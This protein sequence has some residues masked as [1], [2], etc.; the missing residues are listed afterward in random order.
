MEFLVV[1]IIAIVI[2][3]I[4]NVSM[5][6]ILTGILVLVGIGTITFALSFL[7]CFVV[8]LCSKCK[9]AEFVRIGPA[10]GDR[11][12]VAFYMVDGVECPCM[13]PREA[14]LEDKLYKENK[15]YRVMWNQ[16]NGKVFDRYA[17]MTCVLGFVVSVL[18]S[19]G[20]AL[21]LMGGG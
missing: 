1:L 5:H 18:L 3:L 6:C 2:C 7:Y 12:Q 4:L 16:R 13:F 8:L 19:V 20:I 15:K 10:K 11:F 14:I 17:C 21:V 9:E